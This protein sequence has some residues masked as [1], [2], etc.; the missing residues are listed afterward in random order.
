[1]RADQ[2]RSRYRTFSRGISG[3]WRVAIAVSENA[4]Q[5]SIKPAKANNGIRVRKAKMT[6]GT[7]VMTLAS[8][9]PAPCHECCRQRTAYK[10]AKG[11][12]NRQD[13]QK[14]SLMFIISVGTAMTE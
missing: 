11:A 2:R 8:A 10:R 12:E 3:T 6:A 4:G 13:L 1:M 9:S 5:T 7:A 14:K